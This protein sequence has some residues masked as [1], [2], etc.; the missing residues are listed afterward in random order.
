MAGV[1]DAFL[2]IKMGNSYAESIS[3]AEDFP[4][5]HSAKVFSKSI[6]TQVDNISP[7]TGNAKLWK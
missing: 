5:M 1:Q 4:E 3:R 2:Y 7:Q 6:L